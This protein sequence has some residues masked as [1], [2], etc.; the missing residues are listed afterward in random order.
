VEAADAAACIT[1]IDTNTL[2]VY[3]KDAPIAG[4]SQ[5]VQAPA[6]SPGV[7]GVF[8]LA[9]EP[10]STCRFSDRACMA[11]CASSADVNACLCVQSTLFGWLPQRR[12]GVPARA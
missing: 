10:C 5:L 7:D 3:E 2:P 8:Q 1:G 9:P 11:M 6:T 4:E 12:V